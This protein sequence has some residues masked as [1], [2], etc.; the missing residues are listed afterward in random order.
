MLYG[1]FDPGMGRERRAQVRR[2]VERN[3][4][5]AR[6]AATRPTGGT[7]LEKTVSRKSLAARGV[8][9]VVASLK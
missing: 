8:A 3:R 2:E 5:D 4:L 7:G 9:V 1:D 6:L